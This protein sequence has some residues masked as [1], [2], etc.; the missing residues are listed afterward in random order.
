M[1]WTALRISL[2]GTESLSPIP[3][4]VK[5]PI[6]PLAVTKFSKRADDPNATAEELGKIIETDSR[7]TRD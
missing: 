4:R 3:S 5:L 7:P 2:I 6:L 1:N